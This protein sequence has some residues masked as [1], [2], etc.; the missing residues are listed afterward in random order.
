MPMILTAGSC[1]LRLSRCANRAQV[2]NLTTCKDGAIIFNAAR[3]TS[4][5]CRSS[6]VPHGSYVRAAAN[7]LVGIMD[8]STGTAT[9][10]RMQDSIKRWFAIAVWIVG[11]ILSAGL[12]VS[13]LRSG[14]APGFSRAAAFAGRP[15]CRRR[16]RR[17]SGS[18]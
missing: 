14:I 12:V 9:S 4:C 7:R 13:M 17:N 15:A 5:S 11:A 18:C 8:S 16:T 10:F 2:G 3:T 6:T 1:K